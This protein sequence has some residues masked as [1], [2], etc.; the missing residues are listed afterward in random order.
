MEKEFTLELSDPVIM[1]SKHTMS[2]IFHKKI[3]AGLPVTKTLIKYNRNDYRKMKK[4][5][6]NRLILSLLAKIWSWNDEN[7]IDF[8]F[9]SGQEEDEE[10]IALANFIE[11]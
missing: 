11:N 4:K 6:K 1:L 9:S 3:A 10:D 2:H 5:R 8:R 7:A